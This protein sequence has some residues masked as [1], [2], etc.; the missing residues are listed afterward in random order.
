MGYREKETNVLL[1]FERR[2][3]KL[4]VKANKRQT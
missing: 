2:G 1:E 4:A 3:Y